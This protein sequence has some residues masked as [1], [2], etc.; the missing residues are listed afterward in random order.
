MYINWQ[1]IFSDFVFRPKI[2]LHTAA[3]SQ[4]P[5][6]H[7][8]IAST[9]RVTNTIFRSGKNIQKMCLFSEYC[10][11]TVA[12]VRAISCSS[13]S[14]ASLKQVIS[15]THVYYSEVM[16]LLLQSV[17][18]L[19]DR[20]PRGNS[21]SKTS[22]WL[23]GLTLCSGRSQQQHEHNPIRRRHTRSFRIKKALERVME[24][25]SIDDFWKELMKRNNNNGTLDWEVSKL[26][27]KNM[28]GSYHE[29]PLTIANVL[30]V[31]ILASNSGSLLAIRCRDRG[32]RFT[33]NLRIVTSLSLSNLLIGVCVLLDNVK[34]VPVLDSE[35]ETC[36]FL[37]RKVLMNSAHVM[38]LLNL[39]AL[40]VDHYIVVC[41][42]MY[43]FLQRSTRI[44]TVIVTLW[45]LQHDSTIF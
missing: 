27:S 21:T 1:K 22:L 30:A 40:A 33:A 4:N 42:P 20:L 35:A 17:L 13:A 32:A 31:V 36:A 44:M 34:L 19:L 41:S 9:L 11:A 5:T 6:T 3:I 8:Q 15:A 14:A 18:V 25:I 28:R 12:C 2:L 37:L 23:C 39:I 10:E 45:V 24:N 16:P 7:S 38:S 26:V 29:I 43:T